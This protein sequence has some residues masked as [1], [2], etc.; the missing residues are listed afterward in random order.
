MTALSADFLR[1]FSA[2]FMLAGIT[3]G[4]NY[5]ISRNAAYQSEDN[6]E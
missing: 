4:F 1:Q 2:Y 6:L 5:G 3:Y